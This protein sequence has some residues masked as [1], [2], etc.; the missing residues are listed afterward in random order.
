M[1]AMHMEQRTALSHTGKLYIHFLSYD[2]VM[3][4]YYV[5]IIMPRWNLQT[6]FHTFSIVLNLGNS[7]D[8]Q[9]HYYLQLYYLVNKL[10]I[11]V[12]LLL[13]NIIII[14][15]RLLYIKLYNKI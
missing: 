4:I 14:I 1:E 10:C 9:Q 7:V 15:G 8:S 3:E 6:F 12:L 13:N 2:A 5:N 11:S